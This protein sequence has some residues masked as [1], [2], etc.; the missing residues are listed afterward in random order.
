MHINELLRTAVERRASDLHLKAGS[1]AIQGRAGT[2]V[3][4]IKGSYSGIMGLPL[5]ETAVLLRAFGLAVWV[6]PATP[7]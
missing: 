3:E 4:H 6:L 1:Y 7:S 5:Y 2:F